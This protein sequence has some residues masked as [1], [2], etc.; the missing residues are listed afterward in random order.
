VRSEI[1]DMCIGRRNFG[2]KEGEVTSEVTM[3]IVGCRKINKAIS[4][5]YLHGDNK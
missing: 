3:R 4:Q 1:R 5:P 2:D